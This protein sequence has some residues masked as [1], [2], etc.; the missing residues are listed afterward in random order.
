[1]FGHPALTAAMLL[2][3]AP[4]VQEPGKDADEEAKAKIAEFRKE[5]KNCKTD[6]DVAR[7]LG[8]LEE[9]QHPRL[10][11]ELKTWLSKPSTEVAIAAAEKISRY[12]KDKEAADA[13]LNAAGSRKDKDAIV[14]CLR[15]A[16]DV[17]YK[18]AT[19]KLTGYF[20]HRE[21][22]VAR[23]AVDSC[24]KLRSREAVDPLIGL[25]RELEGIRESQPGTGG[26]LGGLAGGGGLG[27]MQEE[28]QKRKRELTPAVLSA[29]SSITGQKFETAA[30]WLGWW[31]KNKSTF[32]EPE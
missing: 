2:A 14:R 21:V 32:K 8:M 29:L 7:A 25:L 20:K 26:G 3:V 22:E 16:G 24:G 31:R 12:K 17:G 11:A 18:P 23:E 15:Y 4:A 13:L 27:G 28:Q 9:P 10:L 1:M 6:Q 30:D 19:A 5:L